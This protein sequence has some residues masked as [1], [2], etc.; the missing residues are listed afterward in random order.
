MAAPD[1]PGGDL[2]VDLLAARGV[3]HV[4]SVSGGP[5]NP[6]YH[7]TLRAPVRIVHTRHEAAAA[8]MAEGTA[9][10]TRSPGV[11]AVTLGPG[12]T[13]TVTPALAATRAGVP[14]LIL[15]GQAPVSMLDREP[16]MSFDPL[17]VI[18]PVTKYAARVV[19]PA[20]I[21]EYLDAA[22][23]A[24]TSGRPGPAFLE[25]PVDV[26]AGAAP[27]PS[28]RRARGRRSGPGLAAEQAERLRHL[29]SGA[30][31]PL[32]VAGDDILWSGADG[33]LAE[34]VDHLRVPFV[35]LRLGRGLMDERHPC[36]AGV[37]YLGSNAPLRSALAQADLVLLIG[38]EF[39]ADLG[40]GESVRDDAVVIQS[41]PDPGVVG[42]FL[43]PDLGLVAGSGA[44]LG[45]LATSDPAGFDRTWCERAARDWRTWRDRA[46]AAPRP[47]GGGIHPAR[48][49]ALLEETM[50]P[51]TTFVTSHGNI[52]FWADPVLRI[53]PPSR[54]LRA[55]QSGALGAEIPFGVAAKLASPAATV[56]VVVGDGGFAFHGLELETA[57]R[58]GAP[59]VVVVYDDEKGGAIALPQQRAYGTEIELDLPRRAWWRVMRAMGGHGEYVDEEADLG[60]ALRRALESGLPAV[61]QVK[62]PS[63]EAPYVEYHS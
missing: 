42:K 44:V 39:E 24:M 53:S 35:T 63:V 19:D 7:G 3:R 2:V 36:S 15:G 20:R 27:P 30:R 50:P 11:C 6:I 58:Y 37:G 61:V 31:R 25:I 13:N 23:A 33:E 46:A 43:R 55:G 60:G 56:V 41:H 29:V 49:S 40:Y 48:L 18:G 10:V 51:G 47:E 57:L 38:H 14:F 12:V 28:A 16:I 59:V 62:V 22:W 4:F 9:R 45:A 32:L 54:Y 26:L 17:P 5:L 52:D 34:A 1:Y 8:F 21:E